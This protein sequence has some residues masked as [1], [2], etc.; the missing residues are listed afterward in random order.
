MDISVAFA[1]SC[2]GRVYSPQLGEPDGGSIIA[3]DGLGHWLGCGLDDALVFMGQTV[4]LRD[5]PESLTVRDTV[6]RFLAVRLPQGRRFDLGCFPGC[7]YAIGEKQNVF[8]DPEVTLARLGDFFGGDCF[9]LYLRIS[10]NAGEVMAGR[11]SG[12]TFRLN[13]RESGSHHVPHVHVSYKHGPEFSV[14]LVDG[15]IL[16]GE[17]E[18]GKIPSR[19]RR[20][21]N[22][23]ICQ[24]R[25]ELLRDWNSLT[26]G[27]RVDVDALLGQVDCTGLR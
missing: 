15:R 26:D 7:Y 20:T 10:G 24:N 18:Y 16:A 1:V 14:S 19:V 17:S 3:A 12:V 2:E 21:I 6:S 23:R 8:V 11:I 25:K 4:V 5:L 13:S 27:I 22:E 9:E